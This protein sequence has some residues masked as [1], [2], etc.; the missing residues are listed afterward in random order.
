MQASN[1]VFIL[2]CIDAGGDT[3]R[4]V[5]DHRDMSS[6]R[7]YWPKTAFAVRNREWQYQM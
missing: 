5:N 2:L 6:A 3:W 4:E 7:Y 1:G